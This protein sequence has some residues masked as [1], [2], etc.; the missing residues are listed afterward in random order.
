MGFNE[1]IRMRIGYIFDDL[2]SVQIQE[3]VKIGGKVIRNFEGVTFRENLK[4]SLLKNV[5][6]SCLL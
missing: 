5:W 6:K 2:R 1:I 4:V 3:F